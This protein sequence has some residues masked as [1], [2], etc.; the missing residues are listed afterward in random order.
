MTRYLSLS[1]GRLDAGSSK[2][3]TSKL[4]LESEQIQYSVDQALLISGSASDL[5][6]RSETSL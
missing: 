5:K 1:L 6:S 3:N 2:P 4:T